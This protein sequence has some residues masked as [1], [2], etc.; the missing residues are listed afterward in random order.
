MIVDNDK[1]IVDTIEDDNE[2]IV[3][4]TIIEQL[5]TW[6]DSFA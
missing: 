2:S 3:S 5:E 1:P 4:T 6:I